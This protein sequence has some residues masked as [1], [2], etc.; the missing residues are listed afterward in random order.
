[1]PDVVSGALAEVL[2][3]PVV[4][5]PGQ[6]YYARTACAAATLPCAVGARLRRAERQARG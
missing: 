6:W 4:C 1:M 5:H 3:G 2:N